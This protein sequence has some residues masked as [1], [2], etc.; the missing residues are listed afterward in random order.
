MLHAVRFYIHLIPCKAEDLNQKD[1]QEAMMPHQA[2]ALLSPFVR[3]AD[4]LVR[5]VRH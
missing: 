4:V 1:F 5:Q 2:S 3:Q